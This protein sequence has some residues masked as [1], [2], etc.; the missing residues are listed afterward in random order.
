MDLKTVGAARVRPMRD[1]SNTTNTE[2]GGEARIMK[3]NE[4]DWF[5]LFIVFAA[6]VA[7]AFLIFLIAEEVYE[8]ETVPSTATQTDPATL[9]AISSP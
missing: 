1:R 7:M 2:T 8:E 6:T 4:Y 9:L 3:W 5:K